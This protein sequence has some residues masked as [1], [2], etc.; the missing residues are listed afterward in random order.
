MGK[1]LVDKFAKTVKGSKNIKSIQ[2]MQRF[3]E[4]Y[5][6]YL[7]TQG[8]VSKH[9]AV[10]GELST[11]VSK[12]K[13][14]DISAIE[15]EI[16]CSNDHKHHFNDVERSIK[17]PNVDDYD[18]LRLAILYALRYQ[19]KSN[20]KAS[21]LRTLLR[22]NVRSEQIAKEYVN[23]LD[24]MLR[25]FGSNKREMNL[26]EEEKSNNSLIGKLG[27]IVKAVNGMDEVQNIYTQHNPLLHHI[28]EDAVKCKLPYNQFPS[29]HGAH[30]QQPKHIIIYFIGGA[31]FEEAETVAQ[32]NKHF[33][34]KTQIVLG[35]G[36][37]HN[38]HS[39]IKDIQ[40]AYG[41]NIF[42]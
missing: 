25:H 5:G 6:D 2:D 16:V 10:M 14:L 39:F 22:N 15:Q 24:I 9:V 34:D 42:D 4:N 35:T 20:D 27:S 11:I 12:R 18:K 21:N 38:S 30:K 41:R 33:G 37:M 7:A 8:N 32:M 23:T 29:F 13:L 31:T 1:K 26:F 36:K 28:I 17:D 3:V 19:N 40:K